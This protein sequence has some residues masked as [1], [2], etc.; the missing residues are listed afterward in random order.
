MLHWKRTMG[1]SL[2]LLLWATLAAAEEVATTEATEVRPELPVVLDLDAAQRAALANNPSLFAAE[3]RVSQASARVKQTRSLYFPQ[4]DVN[5]SATHTELPDNIVRAGEAAASAAA[6]SNL[7]FQVLGGLQQSGPAPALANLVY[8]VVQALKAPHAVTDSVD[9]Y[10]LSLTASYLVFDGFS[11]RFSHAIAKYG[12]QESEAALLETRRLLLDAVAQTFYAVQ[13]ARENTAIAE[14]DIEFNQRLLKDAEA[15]RR[16]GTGSL[17]DVLNFEVRVRAARA[18][19]L[20][21]S[22]DR[23]VA[24][25]ALAALMGLPDAHLPDTT[26]VAS[27]ALEAPSDLAQPETESLVNRALQ[28]R[29]DLQRADFGLG[30]ARATVGQRR[31]GYYPVVGAF[32][33]YGASRSEDSRF[34]DD[35]FATTVGVNVSYSLFTGGRTRASVVEARHARAEAEAILHDAELTVAADVR[36]AAESLET[37]QQQLLLQ[38][39]TAEYV[40]RN[41]DLVEKEYDAGQGALARLNQAQRDLIEAQ[42]R[43]AQAR[44]ALQQRLH[45]LR[46][47]TAETLA[48]FGT[49]SNDTVEPTL[50]AE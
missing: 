36:Q 15:R 28:D 2:C 43:L 40:E 12:R 29:P 35:D 41:R 17:S 5:Y 47:E 46:T 3:A 27:L 19:L 14:A 50:A 25:I 45:T 4:V 39:E 44:V 33:T 49:A 8:S 34:E 23:A 26:Q 10:D 48:R 16:V 37:A 13:L 22:H 42:A 18:A 31:S 1:L 20:S 9:S 6:L 11:R 32:G 30:R 38:R 24:R 7:N 21:A